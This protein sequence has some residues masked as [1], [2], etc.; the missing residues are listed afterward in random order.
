MSLISTVSVEFE[1]DRLLDLID[2]MKRRLL[3]DK[4]GLCMEEMVRELVGGRLKF[5][6]S[7]MTC[8]PFVEAD[9]LGIRAAIERDFPEVFNP[10]SQLSHWHDDWM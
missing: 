6:V 2:Q 3:P 8:S 10:G 9:Y 5:L 1:L 7:R 4:R